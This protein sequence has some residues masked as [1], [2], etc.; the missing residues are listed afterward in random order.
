MQWLTYFLTLIVGCTGFLTAGP[1]ALADEQHVIS[2]RSRMIFFDIPAQ[3]LAAAVEAYS[4]ATGIVAPYNGRLAV[5]RLSGAV[6]GKLTP[7]EALRRLLDRNGLAVRYTTPEAFVLVPQERPEAEDNP[8]TIAFAALSGQ[9][10]AERFY[11]G[12]VQAGVNRSLCS[13][14]GAEPGA[15]RLAIRFRVNSSGAIERPKLLDSTGDRRRDDAIADALV[16]VSVGA[17]PPVGMAQPFTMIILPRSTGA[18]V[19][20]AV[21]GRQNG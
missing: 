1:I 3:P 16:K 20:C 5:G 12:L 10:A 11:S 6:R 17:P 19:D 7:E 2:V 9:N 14:A 4:A 21:K 18:I 8:W 15:Y 13:A